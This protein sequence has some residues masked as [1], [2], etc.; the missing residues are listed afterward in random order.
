MNISGDFAFVILSSASGARAHNVGDVMEI[1]TTWSENIN[2]VGSPTITL[3]N[4]KKA[5]YKYGSANGSDT[6][7][8]FEYTIADGDIQPTEI[9][10]LNFNT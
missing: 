7:A 9:T 1:T 2:V 10:S 4:D 5:Y 6:T 3:S 8:V